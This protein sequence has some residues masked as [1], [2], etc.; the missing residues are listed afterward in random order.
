MTL[1]QLFNQIYKSEK[2]QTWDE[3]GK[4]FN[5]TGE[6]IRKRYKRFKNNI[7]SP[8]AVWNNTV[9]TGLYYT[10][11]HEYDLQQEVA[12]KIEIET[13]GK[14]F[15]G[16]KKENVLVI[17]DLHEPFTHPKAFEFIKETRDK[18]NCT[19]V[20]FIG[21][22]VDFAS[23]SYHEKNPNMPS[24][25]DELKWARK[26]L[27]KWHKEFPNAV[28]LLGNHDLLFSRVIKTAGLPKEVL[29][30]LNEILEVPTWEFKGEY[31]HNDILYTHGTG[32]S[33]SSVN[34]KALYTN[35]S[36]VI[37]HL[38]TTAKI[39]YLRNDLFTMSVGCLIDY[40]HE[41][42][43]YAKTNPKNPIMSCG[44]IVDGIPHLIPMK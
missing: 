20:I 26:Q 11:K 34:T 33:S 19:K 1:E 25:G 10:P 37:G 30:P 17:P 7:T 43:N 31:L 24:P 35:K 22:I 42:F 28:V 16:D 38:H 44:V 40:S 12:K 32:L 8:I 29:R 27:S 5:L 15:F 6:Q 3:L 4:Q 14:L 21:D 9:T 2:T 18:Y 13:L 39:E 36:V 23:I 41:A